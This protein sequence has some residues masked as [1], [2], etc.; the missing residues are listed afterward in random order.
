M[1][2]KHNKENSFINLF[3]NHQKKKHGSDSSDIYVSS[4]SLI[5]EKIYWEL[6]GGKPTCI[7]E[8]RSLTHR[9]T[10]HNSNDRERKR[11]RNWSLWREC[12]SCLHKQT[13]EFGLNAMN[14]WNIPSP[15]KKSFKYL[16]FSSPSF[17]AKL[18]VRK[19]RLQHHQPNFPRWCLLFV[20]QWGGK[21]LTKKE[22]SSSRQQ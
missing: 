11:E 20:E 18:C 5:T 2:E 13:S 17:Y 14:G 8:Q 7:C 10:G 3:P 9:N 15:L 19:E 6:L 21:K 22:N 1:N 12:L 16:T 4:I